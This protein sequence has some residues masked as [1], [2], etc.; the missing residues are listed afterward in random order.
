MDRIS[1]KN[2]IDVDT[3]ISARQKRFPSFVWRQEDPKPDFY[4][5]ISKV[6]KTYRLVIYRHSEKSRSSL[7]KIK[8]YNDITTIQEI[9]DKI[10]E[11]LK[12]NGFKDSRESN[13]L[14]KDIEDF[15][16]GNKKVYFNLWE[17]KDIKQSDTWKQLSFPERNALE[18]KERSLRRALETKAALEKVGV[19]SIFVS[20]WGYD[21]THITSFQVVEKNKSLL[22][23]KEIENTWL[24]K[25]DSMGAGGS[26]KPVKDA[27]V[28]DRDG[29]VKETYK[30]RLSGEY[31]KVDH[32]H[33]SLW[34]G[35]QAF[36]CSGFLSAR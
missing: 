12:A 33:A 23:V 13:E 32:H 24:N 25:E 16:V 34:D 11:H 4:Y 30:T 7:E 22:G 27:F 18:K 36:Y 14:I 26:K 9:K 17:I 2:L 20:S 3:Y 31:I 29:N 8:E 35:K 21:E 6:Y 28:K 15:A 19:G 10:K 1:L 5:H